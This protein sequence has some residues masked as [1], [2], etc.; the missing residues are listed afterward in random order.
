MKAQ[1]ARTLTDAVVGAY[2]AEPKDVI[3]YFFDTVPSDAFHA[4]IA[5]G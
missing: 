2:A 1:A 3:I 5:Q 4:G